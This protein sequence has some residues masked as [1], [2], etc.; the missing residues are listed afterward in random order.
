VIKLKSVE[1]SVY[2]YPLETIVQ[3]SFGTMYDR[4]M[5]LVK[6]TDEDDFAGVGEVWCNFPAVGAEHRARLIESVFKPL[7]TGKLFDGPAKAFDLLTK[8]TWVLG[9]QTG[10]F[11][12]IAQCIAGIDIAFHDLMARRDKTPLWK[13]LGGVSDSVKTYASG[14]NPTNAEKTAETAL[15]A[16]HQALKLKIGFDLAQDIQ[17]IKS[18]RALLGKK[19]QL[20][21]DANQAW[22]VNEAKEMMQ[23]IAAYDIKW[24]EEPIHADRPDDEWRS[25]KASGNTPLAGG[26]N[27]MGDRH[28]NRLIE[29][30]YLSVIQPDLAKWGG[31]TETVP[32]ARKIIAAG[33]RY[34][35]HYLGGGIGLLASAHALAAVGGNGVLEFDI[36]KNPLRS[37]FVDACFK[38][39]SSLMK[40]G[41]S[42][43]LGVE[44]DFRDIS[45]YR[46]Q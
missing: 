5:V 28:F 14:I 23:K 8:K 21:V 46:V 18:L 9:L 12:P 4:P 10:E 20:M 45:K 39:S 29:A 24:L 25:V 44:V 22:T 6:L 13:Y 1:V 41:D 17:N 16:G 7:L 38:T 3:T 40:L 36:N 37:I 35:P 32:V 34:C 30:G 33:I 15:E 26:E 43:G 27:I 31:L 11:G 2:R 42:P 19:G